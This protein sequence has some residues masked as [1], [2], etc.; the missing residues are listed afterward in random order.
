[1]QKIQRAP[2]A[3]FAENMVGLDVCVRII[4]DCDTLDNHY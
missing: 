3:G 2:D 1:M 4:Y